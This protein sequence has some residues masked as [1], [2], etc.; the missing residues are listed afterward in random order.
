MGYIEGKELTNQRDMLAF[1][2]NGF[3]SA[4]IFAIAIRRKTSSAD[5]PAEQTRGTLD[6]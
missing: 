1:A 3:P 2:E 5:R 6:F 4:R